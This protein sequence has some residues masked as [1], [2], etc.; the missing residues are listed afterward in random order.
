MV[1]I[2]AQYHLQQMDISVDNF[3]KQQTP[4]SFLFANRV[5]VYLTVHL[6]E[7]SVDPSKPKSAFPS[8]SAITYW[9]VEQENSV[10]DGKF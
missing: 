4:V 8:T 7:R 6:R 3:I 9:Q 5:P 10:L 1:F 2:I